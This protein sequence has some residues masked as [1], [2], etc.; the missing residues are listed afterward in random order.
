M[1]L[2]KYTFNNGFYFHKDTP[3]AVQSAL[4]EAHAS[5]QTVRIWL[6][7]AVTGRAWDEEHDVLGTIGRSCGPVKVPLLVPRG[8]TGGGH[9]LDQCIVRIDVVRSVRVPREMQAELGGRRTMRMGSTR[10]AHPSF[11]VGDWTQRPSREPG[12]VA[13]VLRDGAVIARFRTLVKAA[14]YVSFM[15]G[16]GYERP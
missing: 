9:L 16:Q 14:A 6:G 15:T 1:D 2:S 12:Y 4:I 8:E 10:Y 3:A 13:E 11:H 5:G 7:D